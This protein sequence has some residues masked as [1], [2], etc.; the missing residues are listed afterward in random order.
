MYSTFLGPGRGAGLEVDSTGDAYVT[1]LVDSSSYP[2]TP[3]S[4]DTVRNDT[5]AFVTKV[6]PTGAT[7]VYSTFLGGSGY[8]EGSDVAVDSAGNAYVTGFSSSVDFPNT[9]GA[10]FGNGFV[11]KL[12][13]AGSRPGLFDVHLGQPILQLQP[14]HRRRPERKG[15]RHR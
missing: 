15:I 14:R 2:T 4:Y 7:L 1:G 9:Q 8:D 13:N 12:N 10:P 6:A 11:T 3:G 5:D